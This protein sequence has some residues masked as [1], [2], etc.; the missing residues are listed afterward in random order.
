MEQQG[1]PPFLRNKLAQAIVGVVKAEYPTVWPN[2][3]RSAALLPS[4]V[5]LAQAVSCLHKATG[6]LLMPCARQPDSIERP[7]SAAWL[8]TANLYSS[9]LLTLACRLSLAVAV[10]GAVC[11]CWHWSWSC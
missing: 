6:A 8:S 4:S 11:C 10:Q 7:W 3:F 9:T 5:L 1:L 2:F